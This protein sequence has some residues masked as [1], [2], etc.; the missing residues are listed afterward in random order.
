MRLNGLRTIQ[1]ENAVC[2]LAGLQKFKVETC[3]FWLAI[4]TFKSL[5]KKIRDAI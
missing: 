2:K 4:L 3:L 1:D 5:R